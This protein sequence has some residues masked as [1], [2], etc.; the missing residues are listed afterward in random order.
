MRVC[1]PRYAD[2]A[3]GRAGA[4]LYGGRW[5]SK[6]RAVVYASEIVSLAALEQLLHVEDPAVL[7]AFVVVS[8]TLYGDAIA[9]LPPSSLPDD[10]RTYPVPPSTRRLGDVWLSEGRSLA[11]KVPSVTVRGQH[12]YLLNP[13]HPNL[14]NI[15]V[16]EPEPLDLDPRITG[17]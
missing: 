7:D 12:N 9:V 16:S 2:T 8:A 13:A 1:A 11:L 3:F 5:N 6:G 10:W 15:D 14:A 4:R 17:P